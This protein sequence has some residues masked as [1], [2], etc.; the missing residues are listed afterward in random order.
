MLKT[1]GALRSALGETIARRWRL[2]RGP[3]AAAERSFF[4]PPGQCGPGLNTYGRTALP[5]KPQFAFSAIAPLPRA[6][7]DWP[8]HYLPINQS[9]RVPAHHRPLCPHNAPL[10]RVR[11]PK[12]T[13]DQHESDMNC[14]N[15]PFFLLRYF[16]CESKCNR[17]RFRPYH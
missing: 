10:G 13:L 7:R 9:A 6:V 15:R 2:I 4:A 16:R 11:P 1:M 8:E 5:T 17:H 12:R 14:P 3:V